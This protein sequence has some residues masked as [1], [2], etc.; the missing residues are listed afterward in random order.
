[1]LDHFYPL[2]ATLRKEK[3][4]LLPQ[5][6]GFFEAVVDAYFPERGFGLAAELDGVT[7][8][9]G[10]FLAEGNELYIKYSATNQS[11]LDLRASN[12]FFR[13]GIEAA[14]AAGYK[15]LDLGLSRHEGIIRFKEHLGA[16][17]TPVFEY[18]YNVREKS[19]AV[20]SIEGALAS[21][22][23]IITGPDVPLGAAQDAGETLYRY[24][25]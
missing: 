6:R 5:G 18:R 23:Q 22:T 7:A 1:V 19:D 20:K 13:N 21:L 11:M 25:A 17:S 14:I 24:F 15:T 3:F 2:Y 4:R 12:F 9:A 10:T 8:A 16:Q